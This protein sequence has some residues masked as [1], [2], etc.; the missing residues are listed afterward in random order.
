MDWLCRS[1]SFYNSHN[2][3]FASRGSSKNPRWK[4]EAHDT[5]MTHLPLDGK[6]N[7]TS[8]EAFYQHSLISNKIVDFY[9]MLSCSVVVASSSKALP[10]AQTSAQQDSPIRRAEFLGQQAP[11]F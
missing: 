7:T 3:T 1:T 9:T 2:K 5:T 10:P 4:L 11:H 8:V 6:S